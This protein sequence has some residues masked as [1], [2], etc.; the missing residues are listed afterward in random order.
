MGLLLGAGFDSAIKKNLTS[1][2]EKEGAEVAVISAKIE[3][4]A[5]AKGTL[6]HAD[7][8]LRA[9]P[10]VLFDAVIVLA[11]PDGDKQFA[12]DPNAVSFLTDAKNHCKAIGFSGIPTLAEVAQIQEAAGIID[13][14][15]SSN[16]KGFVSAAKQARFWDRE[17]ENKLKTKTASS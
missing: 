2:I 10:S 4:E 8:F 7:M 14:T 12:N 3:G 9:S 6:A 16:G 15:K 11:G 5:D 17:T 1:E 13:L